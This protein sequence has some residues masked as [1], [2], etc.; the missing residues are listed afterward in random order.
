[1][2][3]HLDEDLLAA[4]NVLDYDRVTLL[5]RVGGDD[6]DIWHRARYVRDVVYDSAPAPLDSSTLFV[7]VD[8]VSDEP[9]A[10]RVRVALGLPPGQL[11]A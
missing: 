3:T 10:E 1:M 2:E 9:T 6:Q 8:D 5:G 4:V 11:Y 7:H